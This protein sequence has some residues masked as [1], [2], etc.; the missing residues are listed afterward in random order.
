MSLFRP[1][2]YKKNIFEIDYKKLKKDGIKCLVFDL[3][4][5]L[6][7][8]DH[9]KCPDETKKLIKKLEK[10]FLI[11]ISSN[12]TQQRIDPYLE[13]LGI[14][15]VAWSLKPSTRS[16]R[17]IRKNEKLEKDQMVMIGDQI[18]TD[19]L[20]GKRYKIRT[21]LVDPLGKKDLKITGLNRLIE[22]KIVKYYAKRGLFE[23]GK[24]YG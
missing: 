21:I 9:E 18:V 17:R 1:D 13:D 5:T 24:Y 16:L 12:N 19:I 23:R 15:G 14:R 22:N 2:M 3:D 8:I 4:N 7:L 10:D 6:G 11:F 20:A